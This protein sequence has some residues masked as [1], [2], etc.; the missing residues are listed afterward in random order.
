MN[1]S[2][3]PISVNRSSKGATFSQKKFT[4]VKQSKV[5]QVYPIQHTQ[6]D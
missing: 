6:I 3:K 5:H 4:F 2:K 1:P